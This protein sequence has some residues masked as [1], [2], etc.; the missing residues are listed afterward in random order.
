MAMT[1]L[2]GPMPRMT[3]SRALLSEV[4][5][6]ARSPLATVHLVCGLAA[7][8]ACGEYF[9]V[10]RWDPALGA[11]A[12]AQF[13]GALMPLMSAIVCRLAV[14]EERAAGRLANLTAVPSRG[15]AVAAKLLALAALGAGALAV[16]LG[17]FG[18]VLAVAG[19]LPLGPAPLA[20]AWAG[21]VLGSLPLYALGLGVALRLGR[22]AAIGAGA[23]GMLLAFFSVGGLAHGLMTGEL[24]GALETP[25][26]WVPLACPRAWGRSGWRPS[27][28]PHARRGPSSRL[29]SPASCSP[30]QPPPSFSPGSAASRTGGQMRRKPLAAVLA[31]LS[32]ALVLGGNTLLDA[33]WGSALRSVA[34]RVLPNPEIAMWAPAPEP[35][36]HASSYADATGAGANYVYLVDAADDRGNVRE[37]QL[38]FFGRESDGEGWLE[39][40]ARGG[41]GVRY[42]ACDAAEAP[43]AARGALD[44]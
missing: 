40:E 33:G 3:L 30:W 35:G 31:L 12:Y 25:L 2:S 34:D 9:S 21:I 7:G 36:S 23:A 37:L 26:S 44:R 38:I 39:I 17:V 24:T 22:N 27:S 6:L 41:S 32:A 19:R 1:R 11:D 15:R 18:A 42:R 20:A 8:L 28:T 29:R 43:A 10:T 13:L 14:D 16:A 5:R 4:L